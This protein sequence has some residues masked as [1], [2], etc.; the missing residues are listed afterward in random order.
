MLHDQAA[1][2][3]GFAFNGAP[4]VRL[5]VEYKRDAEG[6]MIMKKDNTGPISTN[7]LNKVGKP[8]LSTARRLVELSLKLAL[9]PKQKD[10]DAS[11]AGGK[12]SPGAGAKRK[13]DQ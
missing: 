9:E 10:K 2:E 4:V 3:G 11:S 1:A 7:V 13:L 5:K 12:V 8:S 6:K